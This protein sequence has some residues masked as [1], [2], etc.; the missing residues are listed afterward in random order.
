MKKT[1]YLLRKPVEQIDPTLFF[2]EQSKGDVVL[3]E[4]SGCRLFPYQGG[5]VFF[6]T[7]EAAE[8]GLTY[9]TLVRKIFECDHTIVI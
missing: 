9:D 3:L 5:S 7:D 8:H 1:L 2:P 4:E 6:L